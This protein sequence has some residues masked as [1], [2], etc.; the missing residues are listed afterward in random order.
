MIINHNLTSLSVLNASRATNDMLKKSI[1]PLATGMRINS[2]VDDASGLAISERMKSQIYGYTMA[3]RNAQDGMSLLQT[4]EGALGEADGVLHRMRELTVQAAND[5]YTLQDRKH[6][7]EELDGLKA[8]LNVIADNTQ[9]NRK[10]LLDG[11]AGLLWSSSDDSLRAIVR[12]GAFSLDKAEGNYRI[13]IRAT[14][15]KAQVQQS[16]M[17]NVFTMTREKSIND[18]DEEIYTEDIHV[19]NLREMSQF[20]TSE[21]AFMIENPQSIAIIQGNGSIADF[22]LYADDTIFDAAE[23]IN[24]AISET[25]GQ[26]KYTMNADNF[27]SVSDAELSPLYDADGN[28]TGYDMKA[29]IVVQS[30]IPGRDGELYFSG[31][32]DVIAALGLSTIQDSSESEYSISVY[33]AHTSEAL[34]SDVKITGNI[35]HEVIASNVDVQFDAMA[36]TSAEWHESS[37]TYRLTQDSTGY[38]GT[39]HLK[40]S[41]IIFQ[42]GTNQAE[43]FAV[44]FGD[45]SSIGLGLEGV[46]VM[47]R[48][49]ASRSIS[50]IDEAIDTVVKNRTQIVSYSSSLEHSTANLA[51]SGSNLVSSR[52]RLTDA[53]TARSTVRFIEFQI[54]SHAQEAILTQANQQPEAVYSL[55][56]KS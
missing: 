10:T 7:Q 55:L 51:S 27:A 31:N 2:A 6:I 8:K 36:G 45:V 17:F 33:D 41:G 19:N 28:I 32:D 29:G 34:A 15:G 44:Q 20:Y 53:D 9:F 35:L 42:V 16:S 26:G 56:N 1:Q 47:S 3:I 54:L 14:P 24:H 37:G 18:D 5:T 30:V 52:S 40:N 38:S 48:E 50:M 22:T 12:G 21:E 46:S 25:L 23:K 49:L 39:I 11:S 4:A 13:E 43:N